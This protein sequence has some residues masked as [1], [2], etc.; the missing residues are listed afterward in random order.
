MAVSGVGGGGDSCHVR[1]GCEASAT[2]QRLRNVDKNYHPETGA[3]VEEEVGAG[4][5][6]EAGT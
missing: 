5:E 6:A 2:Q 3:A 1:P 4:D